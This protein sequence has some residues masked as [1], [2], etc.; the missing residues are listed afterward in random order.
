MT[1]NSGPLAFGGW[2]AGMAGAAARSGAGFGAGSQPEN[3]VPRTLSG[4]AVKAPQP[5]LGH[6]ARD[7]LRRRRLLLY[8]DSS[9]SRPSN[10]VRSAAYFLSRSR[11]SPD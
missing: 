7:H 6:S 10:I 4:C 2:S 9:Y 3:P 11:L 1:R 8:L 5:V